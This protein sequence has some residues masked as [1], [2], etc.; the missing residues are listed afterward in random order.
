MR[1]R[2]LAEREHLARHLG[3]PSLVGLEERPR[4]EAEEEGQGERDAEAEQR[5]DTERPGAVDLQAEN[6]EQ[7]PCDRPYPGL[8]EDADE[9][10]GPEHRGERARVLERQLRRRELRLDLRKQ[11]QR[12]GEA[13]RAAQER[14]VDP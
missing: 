12:F 11:Q 9:G 8:A 2:P 13:R 10:R 4:P 5:A 14:V 3:I 6:D 7:L 1:D